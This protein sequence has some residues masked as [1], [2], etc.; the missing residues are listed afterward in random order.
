MVLLNFVDLAIGLALLY[1]AM[2]V[3]IVAAP[4]IMPHQSLPISPSVT[5]AFN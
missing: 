3:Q 2:W 4:A 5:G 1:F